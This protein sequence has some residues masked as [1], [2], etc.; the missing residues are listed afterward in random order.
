[1][2]NPGRAGTETWRASAL[3]VS[4]GLAVLVADQIAKAWAVASLSPPVGAQD[5]LGGWFR[6]ILITNNGAAFGLLGGSGL[7][8]VVVGLVLC[9]VIL[10]YAYLPSRTPILQVSLG[11]QLGGAI[12][13]LTDRVRI[14]H[15]VDFIQIQFWPIFNLADAAIA[16]GVGL[17]AYYV[18]SNPGSGLPRSRRSPNRAPHGGL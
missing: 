4:V 5:I 16:C 10:V 17:L 8:L 13:N 3:T 12:G 6:L 11:L 9:A 2:N 14:G 7:L 1:M 18:M 15:V